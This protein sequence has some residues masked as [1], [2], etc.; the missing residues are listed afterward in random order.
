M[1]KKVLFL[2]IHNSARSQMA[3]EYLRKLGGSNFETESAG[4]E[5]TMINPLVVK[6][7]EEEGIYLAGK[8]T[9]SVYDLLKASRFFGYLITVCDRAKEKDCPVFPGLGYKAHWD[10]EDPETFTGTEQEKLDKVR[11]LRDR[12][13]SLVTEFITEQSEDS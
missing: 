7:M 6:V 2:C 9:K 4:Y 5:P 10:L 3:E 8:R 12:I 11:A 13:K 1:K